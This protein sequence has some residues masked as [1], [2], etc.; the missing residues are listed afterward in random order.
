MIYFLV[1]RWYQIKC[2]RL[3]LKFF[4]IIFTNYELAWYQVRYRLVPDVWLVPDY[5]PNRY[6]KSICYDIR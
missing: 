5:N 3:L 1:S 4:E 6:Q 2:G